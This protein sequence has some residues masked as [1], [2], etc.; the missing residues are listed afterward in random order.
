MT[1][2]DNGAATQRS[3][4]RALPEEDVKLTVGT[5]Q[6]V[7]EEQVLL[8]DMLLWNTLRR[9]KCALACLRE[10]LDYTQMRRRILTPAQPEGDLGYR[11]LAF[12]PRTDTDHVQQMMHSFEANVHVLENILDADRRGAKDIG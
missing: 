4:V 1:A 3:S 7:G 11:N 5:Y 8:T 10:R 12:E 2:D 6:V 9:I